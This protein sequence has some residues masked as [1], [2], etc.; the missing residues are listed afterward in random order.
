MQRTEILDRVARAHERLT[1]A[2]DGLTEEQATRKGVTQE[3]SARD[4]LSHIT[5][6]EI[7]GARIVR[8]VQDG[9]YQPQRINKDFI[10]EFNA[11]AVEERRLRSMREVRDEFDGAHGEMERLINSLPDEVDESSPAFKF[12][13]GV[14][15]RHLTHHAEQ[16]ENFQEREG[17]NR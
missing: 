12:I 2:L 9:T 15:F 16:I 11:R 8:S 5:A 3:W 4:A 7:E 6:W 10:E 13:E 14:T 17:L 1:H